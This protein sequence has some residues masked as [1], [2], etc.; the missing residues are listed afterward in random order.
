MSR[1]S[2]FTQIIMIIVAAVIGFYY[3]KPTVTKIRVTQDLTAT[4][5]AEAAK[6]LDVNV[7]L[8]QR[9]EKID[10]VTLGDS[11]ALKR[12]IPDTVDEIAVMK[13]LAAIGSDLG[14]IFSSLTYDGATEESV[15][16]ELNTEPKLMSHAFSI[17]T[18]VNY[19]ELKQLLAALEIN[20]YPLQV[21]LLD[22]VPDK[23][24]LLAV[25]LSIQTFSRVPVSDSEVRAVPPKVIP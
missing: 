3:I 5:E 17:E 9:I 15:A 13:D 22:I 16:E 2:L 12:Y 1:I 19:S 18:D 7:L 14:I 4:Y 8:K 24:G 21:D 20:N 10:S 25:S 11:D 23:T 6:V